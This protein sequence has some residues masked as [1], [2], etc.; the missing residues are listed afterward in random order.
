G[1]GAGG[2]G[3]SM[4]PCCKGIKATEPAKTTQHFPAAF[5]GSV[6]AIAVMALGKSPSPAS[7][8]ALSG[9]GPPRAAS[10]AEAILSRSFQSHAPAGHGL[11]SCR[12]RTRALAF[13]HS[14]IA[15]I[16]PMAVHA[17]FRRPPHSTTSLE[18]DA[19]I[20]QFPSRFNF[21]QPLRGLRDSATHVR[22]HAP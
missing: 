5:E 15:P 12:P 18:S 8:E 20:F 11:T 2:S 21:N 19:Q 7:V 13:R 10:F 4:S 17:G 14:A 16:A 3:A 6:L 22:T 1:D 9:A